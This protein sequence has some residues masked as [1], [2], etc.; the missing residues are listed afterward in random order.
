MGRDVR[1]TLAHAFGRTADYVRR[2]K[3]SITAIERE[4]EQQRIAD[5]LQRKWNRIMFE[6]QRKGE[7][8]S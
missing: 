6:D 1:T 3:K 4:E 5:R 2:H 7:R 8:K